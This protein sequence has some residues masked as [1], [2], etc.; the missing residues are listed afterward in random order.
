MSISFPLSHPCF[1][2]FCLFSY[3]NQSTGTEVWNSGSL[4]LPTGGCIIEVLCL[5]IVHSKSLVIIR[6]QAIRGSVQAKSLFRD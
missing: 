3:M 2:P 6:L 1:L 4:P 5:L